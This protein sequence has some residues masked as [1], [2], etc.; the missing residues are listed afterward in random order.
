MERKTWNAKVGGASA[1]RPA[2][3]SPAGGTRRRAKRAT[4]AAESPPLC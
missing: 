2:I 4:W 3:G 1:R